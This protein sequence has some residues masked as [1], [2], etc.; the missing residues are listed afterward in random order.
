MA[1]VVLLEHTI[2]TSIDGG[3]KVHRELFGDFSNG[4][5]C[6]FSTRRPRIMNVHKS[7]SWRTV[8]AC[9]IPLIL[10]CSPIITSIS[11]CIRM[12]STSSGVAYTYICE[13]LISHAI[14]EARIFLPQLSMNPPA[15]P[16]KC[17]ID[18]TI[19]FRLHS[20]DVEFRSKKNPSSLAFT[21]PL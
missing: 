12:L 3:S 10:Y 13:V 19:D 7:L 18:P 1:A 16:C 4:L 14:T 5:N 9:A 15:L 2:A 20:V 11:K 21:V 17:T 6:L 8:S